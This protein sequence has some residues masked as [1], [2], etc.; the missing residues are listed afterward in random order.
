[1]KIFV[2]EQDPYKAK[3]MQDILSVYKYKV[4]TVGNQG[5]LFKQSHRIKPA[6]IVM[7]EAFAQS[8]TNEILT[9]LRRN[10]ETAN[11]PVIYIRNDKS[12]EQQ[13]AP[14]Q[15]DGLTEIVQ[16]PIKIKNLRHYIDRW[17]TFRSLYVK[18]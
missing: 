3:L 13:L 8:S 7:N 15:F 16:E 2:C 1:M 10:P 18:H 5:D 9:D 14:Y 6:I 11:I 17:T 4:V 12:I